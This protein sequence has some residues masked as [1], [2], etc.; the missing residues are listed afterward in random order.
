MFL[1]CAV[2]GSGCVTRVDDPATLFNLTPE[3]AQHRALQTRYFETTDEQALLSASAAVLQDLGFQVQES[4]HDLAL[5]R[6]SKERSAYE[7]GQHITRFFMAA[8]GAFGQ[9]IILV[10]IDLHQK[11]GATLAM[12]PVDSQG[13]RYSVRITFYRVIW[14]SD[15]QSGDHYIPPGS[16]RMEMIHDATIY[17]QFF[18]KL[19][20]SVFLEA[21]KI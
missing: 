15:G 13:K 7:Y 21:H 1:I 4:V 18:A 5:L 17:Q 19:S 20:K 12:R 8:L 14:E 9:T 10:P 6:A 11:I 3:S 2:M 16:Q